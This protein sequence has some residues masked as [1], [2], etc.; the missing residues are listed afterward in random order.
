MSER[1]A[2]DWLIRYLVVMVVAATALLMLIYGLVFAPSV[3]VT[4]GALVA[5]A[6]VSA[7]VV[8]DLRSWRT[9]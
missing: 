8:M 7:V 4:A 2:E 1:E 3:A 5:L 9:A 6:A